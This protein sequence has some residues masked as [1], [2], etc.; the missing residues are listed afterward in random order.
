MWAYVCKCVGA[1]GDSGCLLGRPLPALFTE[2]KS[3]SIEIT[4]SLASQL[5]SGTPDCKAS[6]LS[7][8]SSRWP[9]EASFT[10]NYWT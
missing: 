4:A 5:A 7:P 10:I 8:E 3:Q 9:Q 6:A 2:I 1:E